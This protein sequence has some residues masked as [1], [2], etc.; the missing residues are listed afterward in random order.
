MAAAPSGRQVAT[1]W[2][3]HQQGQDYATQEG[4][5]A[6]QAWQLTQPRQRAELFNPVEVQINPNQVQ[7]AVAKWERLAGRHGTCT[8]ITLPAAPWT[9]PDRPLLNH[10]DPALPPVDQ[11][12]AGPCRPDW[13]PPPSVAPATPNGWASLRDHIGLEHG[14]TFEF[15]DWAQDTQLL[16]EHDLDHWENPYE[17]HPHG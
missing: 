16:E 13:F 12:L 14:L 1:V 17:D 5:T 3:L 2:L 11:L 9:G 15:M 4:L 6:D 10:P 7:D 8:A